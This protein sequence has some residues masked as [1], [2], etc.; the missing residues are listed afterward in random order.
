MWKEVA[1]QV[2]GY[3]PLLEQALTQLKKDARAEYDSMVLLCGKALHEVK[4]LLKKIST[5]LETHNPLRQLQLGYS[6]LFQ[7][8]TV[9]KKVSGAKVGGHFEAK[10][11]DGTLEA[12]I[13]KITKQNT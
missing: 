13:T 12:S 4:E 1:D 8:G 9:L 10:L 5:E 11:S 3:I 7:G 6:I 2:L